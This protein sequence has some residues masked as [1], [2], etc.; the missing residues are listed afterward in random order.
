MCG[1]WSKGIRSG[2]KGPLLSRKY[3]LELG[4]ESDWSP[5]LSNDQKEVYR[6]WVPLTTLHIHP[7]FH[8]TL[9]LPE[10]VDFLFMRSVS[11]RPGIMMV[12]RQ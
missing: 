2:N 9:M 5:T 3:V 11:Y 4:T 7:T 6:I 10:E 12:L 8:F 1:T